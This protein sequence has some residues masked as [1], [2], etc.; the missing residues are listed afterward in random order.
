MVPICGRPFMEYQLEVLR[1]SGVTEVV[2]CVGYL[3]HLIEQYFEDG[4][5]FDI[6]IRYEAE[7]DGL[8]GT[9]GA[10]KNAERQL[11]EA[12]FVVNGDTYPTVDF[13][14][15]MR[16]FLKYHHLGLMVVF[17]NEDRWDRSNVIIEGDQVR[18]YDKARK[19]PEMVYIDFG[20]SVFRREAFADVRAGVAADLSAVYQAL[21]ARRQLLA[22]EAPHRF[23]EVGS[24]EGLHEFNSLVQSGGLL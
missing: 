13:L 24:P 21:I 20:L 1:R 16:H 23:Y 6:S 10:I 4:A 9:A 12:F 8:L 19:L 7:Q 17:R 18:V 3:G 2:V 22:Y 11:A 15:I 14:D 5:R